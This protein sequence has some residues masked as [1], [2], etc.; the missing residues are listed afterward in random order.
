M[1]PRAFGPPA[2]LMDWATIERLYQMGVEFGSHTTGHELLPDLEMP[3]VIDIAMRSR[4]TLEAKLSQPV[5]KS[6]TFET[7]K[8]A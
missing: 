3:N 6:A 1:S 7:G 5:M 4:V 8:S 2:R